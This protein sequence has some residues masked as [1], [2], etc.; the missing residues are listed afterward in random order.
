MEFFF[1]PDTVFYLSVSYIFIVGLAKFLK[2]QQSVFKKQTFRLV[3][4]GH[5]GNAVAAAEAA[6]VVGQVAEGAR[7]CGLHARRDSEFR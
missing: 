6:P 7:I 5:V 2:K 4:Q 1:T 3:F